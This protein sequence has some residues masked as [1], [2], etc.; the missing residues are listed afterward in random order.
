MSIENASG[1]SLIPTAY[2]EMSLAT[3]K[4]ITGEFHTK[5]LIF[6]YYEKT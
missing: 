2:K 6:Y 3:Q 1:R 4:I 5:G